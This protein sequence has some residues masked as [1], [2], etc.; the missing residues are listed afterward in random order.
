[1]CQDRRVVDS[2]V[3]A[4]AC[5]ASWC[6]IVCRTRALPTQ[7]G[8]DA[9]SVARR[10]PNGYPD[11][12]TL[13]PMVD[14]DAVLGRVEGSA[15]CSVKD[16]FAVLD[17][18]PWGFHVLFEA[19]WI[20]RSI[21]AIRPVTLDWREVRSPAELEQWSRGHDLDGFGPALLD[22]DDLRF[23]Y[24]RSGAGA[25]FA[26]GKTTLVSEWAAVSERRVAW[27]SLDEEDSEPTRFLAYVVAALQTIDASIGTGV[28]RLLQAPQPPPTEW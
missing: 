19:T 8:D 14:A 6:D 2:V 17:L 18:E 27:L 26:F 21:E 15:G 25:G 13:S 23:F 28:L 11:A 10:S 22:F 24:T 3:E 1:L 7:W 16:S 4:A 5:N 9:W 12:V 20:R